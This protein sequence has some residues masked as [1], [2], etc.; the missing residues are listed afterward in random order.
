MRQLLLHDLWPTIARLSLVGTRVQAAIAYVS[1][2]DNLHL[3]S[4]DL[5]IADA[6]ENAIKTAQTSARVLQHF[7]ERGVALYHCVGLHAKLLVIDGKLIVG[8]GNSSASSASRLLEAAILT[9]DATLVSQAQ[10]FLYQLAERSTP[11]DAKAL[12]RLAEIKVKRRFFP[13]IRGKRTRIVATGNKTW[14]VMVRDLPDSAFE[15]ETRRVAAA[16]RLIAKRSPKAEPSILKFWGQRGAR[17]RKHVESGDMICVGWSKTR[18]ATPVRIEPPASILDKREGEGCTLIFYDPHL[19]LPL[20]PIKWREFQRLLKM[21]DVPPIKP[22][23][24]R[25]ITAEQAAE[26]RRIWPRKSP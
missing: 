25:S 17:I 11:L 26:L 5:L 1:S 19:S 20:V 24:V 14:L 9:T 3:R 15:A 22:T 10:S 6:S 7:L 4:G 21:A 2:A 8:S 12:A 16:E 23:S 13:G 18:G